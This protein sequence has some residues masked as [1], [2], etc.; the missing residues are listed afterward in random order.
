M[1]R[2]VEGVDTESESLE[3]PPTFSTRRW[4]GCAFSET[5]SGR[6]FR[7]RCRNDFARGSRAPLELGFNTVYGWHAGERSHNLAWKEA[8]Y[9]AE[10]SEIS[11]WTVF[12]PSFNLQSSKKGPFCKLHRDSLGRLWWHSDPNR[13]LVTLFLGQC[14]AGEPDG[15]LLPLEVREEF[16]DDWSS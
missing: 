12:R 3:N 11:I 2:L 5:R 4:V 7:I 10:R 8:R 14:Y 9:A 1:I 15:D 13:M 16:N 6:T